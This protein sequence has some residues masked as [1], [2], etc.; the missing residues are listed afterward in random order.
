MFIFGGQDQ[1][2][3][4]LNDLWSYDTSNPAI[5]WTR[6]DME[7]SLPPPALYNTAMTFNNMHEII[8]YGGLDKD[9]KSRSEMY[10]FDLKNNEW[11]VNWLQQH[12]PTIYNHN[13]ICVRKD[14]YV[15]G[16]KRDLTNHETQSFS[17]LKNVIDDAID[18]DHPIY[19]RNAITNQSWCDVQFMVKSDNEDDHSQHFIPCHMFMIKSACPTFYKNIQSTH[20]PEIDLPIITNISAFH[21]SVVKCMVEYIYC[22]DLIMLANRNDFVQEMM[23]LSL[24]MNES[25]Q[26]AEVM[27][28]CSR[29]H[30]IQ[31]DTTINTLHHL[32]HIM[33]RALQMSVDDEH[34]NVLV[35][36]TNSQTGQ[37]KGQYKVHK[38]IL[39]K[40]LY[41]R[42]IFSSGMI[43]SVT[44]VVQFY[45]LTNKAFEVIR[46]YLYTGELN[47]GVD[48]CLEVYVT[49][50]QYRMD[51]LVKHCSCLIVSLLSTD[52]IVDIVQI[53][54]AYNDKILLR[55]CVV[56]VADNYLQVTQLEGW[57]NVSDAIKTMASNKHVSKQKKALSKK[58]MSKKKVKPKK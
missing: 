14:M 55:Q 40:S 42:D 25:S 19:M 13:L 39:T 16:G 47:V 27:K 18:M 34:C 28:M 56:F 26:H 46:C 3:K 10:I 30:D 43:E 29:G 11:H 32:D 7:H 2:S 45:D 52:N 9:K 57:S 50:L 58:E 53:A 17:M 41:A 44:N 20:F 1:N 38:L 21:M 5:G 4:T 22:G 35:E 51:A 33:K 24:L 12:Q 23:E 8:L 48:V 15:V 36:L 31:L 54:D 49:G 37:V 6:Y